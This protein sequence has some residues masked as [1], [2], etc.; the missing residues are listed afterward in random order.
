MAA[1]LVP[2]RRSRKAT[3]GSLQAHPYQKYEA[4]ILW[5][6]VSKAVTELVSNRDLTETTRHEYIVGYICKSIEDAKKPR[7]KG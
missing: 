7:A 5:G 4:S 3:E 2:R 6:V 1:S